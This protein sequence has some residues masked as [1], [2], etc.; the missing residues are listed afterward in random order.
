MSK[1]LLAAS[2]LGKAPVL[3]YNGERLT[4]SGAII[5]QLLSEAKN[6]PPELETKISRDSMFWSHFSE[7]SLMMYIQPRV[8]V[9]NIAAGLVARDKGGDARGVKKL[10]SIMERWAGSN[11]TNALKLMDN[12]LSKHPNFSGNEQIG[13]ADVGVFEAGLTVV[14]DVVCSEP[15]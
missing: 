11:R 12:F 4:E 2:P 13:Q 6:P 7:G 8:A 9:N 3:E 1:T 14:Y 5:F 15:A 10:E